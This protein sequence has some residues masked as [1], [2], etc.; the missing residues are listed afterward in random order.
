[1]APSLA[2]T[3]SATY[4]TPSSRSRFA[5]TQI[6]PPNQLKA[7]ARS[8]DPKKHR[9]T[10]QS[11][12]DNKQGVTGRWARYTDLKLSSRD[13]RPGF[14]PRLTYLTH[15]Q[16]HLTLT[17]TLVPWGPPIRAK[18]PHF[19]SLSARRGKTRRARRVSV[20]GMRFRSRRDPDGSV[21]YHPSSPYPSFVGEYHHHHKLC[22]SGRW[23]LKSGGTG[24]LKAD[25]ASSCLSLVVCQ[26]RGAITGLWYLENTS[27]SS[28]RQS[29][30][31]Y[32]R[33]H[34]MV[35]VTQQARN[36]NQARNRLTPLRHPAHQ[37]ELQQ[38][39]LQHRIES[40]H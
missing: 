24:C 27:F 32:Y 37:V 29:E 28:E 22:H 7:T 21:Q 13:S 20:S 31:P 4:T 35:A 3:N 34:T 12:L 11:L 16:S 18:Q 40:Q 30:Y 33:E 2:L 39:K 38:R 5:G 17:L 25:T 14:P 36:L 15:S 6:P 23:E 10:T 26:P 9:N 8:S 1:M 19:Y